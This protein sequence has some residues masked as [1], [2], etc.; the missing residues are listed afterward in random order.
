MACWDFSWGHFSGFP[1][2]AGQGAGRVALGAEVREV[3]FLTAPPLP[4]CREQATV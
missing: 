2:T 1:S 3:R 4:E